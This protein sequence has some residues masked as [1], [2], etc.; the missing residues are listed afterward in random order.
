[1]GLKVVENGYPLSQRRTPV[2]ESR[3][4]QLDIL[5]ADA[6][7]QSEVRSQLQAVLKRERSL[8]EV[9]DRFF[10]RCAVHRGRGPD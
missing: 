1:M 6:A 9:S 4:G 5:E 8:V 7:D 10:Y 2:G 3:A